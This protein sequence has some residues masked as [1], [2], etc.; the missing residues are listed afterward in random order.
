MGYEVKAFH[1]RG[2][3]RRTQACAESRSTLFWGDAKGIHRQDQNSW[4]TAVLIGSHPTE[5]WILL[6]LSLL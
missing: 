1:E 3:N 5:Q 2:G 6:R 4:L